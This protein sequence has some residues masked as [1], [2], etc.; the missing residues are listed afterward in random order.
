MKR[1]LILVFVLCLLFGCG[2]EPKAGDT[3]VRET[4]GMVM[5]YVPVGEFL[6]GSTDAEVE[7]AM[8]QCA[9]CSRE[10]FAHERPQHKVYLDSFWIDRTEVANAQYRR[11]V[12]A[13]A[14]AGGRLPT[15]AEW[16]KAAAWDAR[17]GKQVYPWGTPSTEPR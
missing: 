1:Y 13:G 8:A 16:E 14:W 6:M 2:G 9:D 11:C 12:E 15:E 3:R 5:V 7:A 17:R 10:W 4:D